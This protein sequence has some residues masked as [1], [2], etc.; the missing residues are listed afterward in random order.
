V[1]ALETVTLVLP[2]SRMR[3]LGFSCLSVIQEK[4]NKEGEALDTNQV[5]IKHKDQNCPSKNFTTNPGR[6]DFSRHGEQH[7]WK[8]YERPSMN[9]PGKTLST[10]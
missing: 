6:G 7:V 10:N 4:A 3:R 2:T 8:R 9:F 5:K 1:E